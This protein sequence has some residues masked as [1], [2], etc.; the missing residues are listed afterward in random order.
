MR[1]RFWHRPEPRQP[2]LDAL[3]RLDQ[4]VK[5]VG[6]AVALVR[7]VVQEGR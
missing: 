1:L 4:A 2:A 5:E 3:A 6:E 7:S